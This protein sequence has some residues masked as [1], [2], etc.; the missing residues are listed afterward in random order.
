MRRGFDGKRDDNRRERN[1]T[2]PASKESLT[3]EEVWKNAAMLLGTK[4][5]D[6]A[7]KNYELT[8]K[9]DFSCI[10]TEIEEINKE[11]IRSQNIDDERVARRRFHEIETANSLVHVPNFKELENRYMPMTPT[12]VPGTFPKAPLYIF[13]NQ[14]VFK[15]LDTD[16]LFFIFY[17]QLGTIQQYYAATQLKLYSWRFHTKYFTWFQRLDEPKLITSDYER[18]DFLFFDYDV[19]WSFMK[20]SDFTFEYKYLECSEW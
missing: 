10:D 3:P 20:K 1:I 11:R 12:N 7:P 17:S 16:T 18:G 8:R 15:K 14:D 6:V 9:F 19:T 4:K 5:K 2:K 13:E